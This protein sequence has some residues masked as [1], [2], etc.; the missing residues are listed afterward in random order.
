M[1]L[2]CMARELAA[3][4]FTFYPW[5]RKHAIN[6]HKRNKKTLFSLP[7]LARVLPPLR[8][9]RADEDVP[10][11]VLDVAR[12]LV[13]RLALGVVQHGQV[14]LLHH[15]GKRAVW[16]GREEKR[17]SSLNVL[18]AVFNLLEESISCEIRSV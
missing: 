5:R 3:I 17:N 7:H 1:L 18:V 10:G 12:V 6:S 16:E 11:D 9:P 4:Y 15:R 2:P 14:H 8:V 13:H